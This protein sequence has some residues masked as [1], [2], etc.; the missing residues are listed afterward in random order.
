MYMLYHLRTRRRKYTMDGSYRCV[1][2][3]DRGRW[4]PSE[5]S[6]NAMW[7]LPKCK[8]RH[9]SVVLGSSVSFVL[10]I[11][12]LVFSTETDKAFVLLLNKLCLCGNDLVF[13]ISLFVSTPPQKPI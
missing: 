13:A 12:A 5:P 4:G 2:Y 9:N 1:G 3:P 7:P 8:N 6:S 10:S 11:L